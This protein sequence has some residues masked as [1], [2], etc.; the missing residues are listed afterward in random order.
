ETIQITARKLSQSLG[1]LRRKGIVPG[2]MYGQSL[3]ESLP[4]QI[5]VKDLQ[6]IIDNAQNT[7]TFFLDYEGTQH[8]CILRE[9]QTDRLHTQF[10]HVDFQYVKDDEI[11]KMQIPVAYQGLE[12]LNSKKLILEKFIP[13]VPVV[14]PIQD[15]PEAVSIDVGALNRGAKILAKEVALPTSTTLLLEP[16]VIL[17][18]V[19]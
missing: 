15:L 11:I 10:L 2:I 12:F 19:Q 8:E 13:K 17:A 18:T 3:K 16:E 5:Q 4:I 6:R 7:T 1:S 9:Y 14:G